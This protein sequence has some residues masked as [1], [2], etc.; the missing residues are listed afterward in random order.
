VVTNKLSIPEALGACHLDDTFTPNEVYYQVERAKKL[1]PGR[2]EG[3]VVE[4]VG[5]E[6]GDDSPLTDSSNS[7][8]Q[9][10]SSRSTKSTLSSSKSNTSQK[11]SHQ[12][13]KARVAVKAE[14]EENNTIYKQALKEATLLVLGKQRELSRTICRRLNVASGG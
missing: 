1:L 8:E 5:D 13:S 11:T 14:R 9:T 6:S 4:C 7:T 10:S 3:L 2:R 12:A